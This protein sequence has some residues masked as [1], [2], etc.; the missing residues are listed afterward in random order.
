MTFTAAPDG[1]AKAHRTTKVVAHNR[2]SNT[3]LGVDVSHKYSD[4]YK[5]FGA[6]GAISPD[7]TSEPI[8]V[9]YP[10]WFC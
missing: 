1:V 3:I 2:T 10:T 4:Y 8:E 9:N 5:D 6:W 7:G